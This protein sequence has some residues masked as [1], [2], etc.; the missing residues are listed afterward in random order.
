MKPESTNRPK[1][2]LASSQ[3]WHF[4]CLYW[5]ALEYKD[6]ISVHIEILYKRNRRLYASMSFS[7]PPLHIAI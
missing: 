2:G 5:P 6:Y 4:F 1:A 7:V 3:L